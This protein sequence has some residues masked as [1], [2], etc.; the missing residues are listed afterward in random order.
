MDQITFAMLLLL[1]CSITVLILTTVFR[2]ILSNYDNINQLKARIQGANGWDEF[3]YWKWELRDLYCSVIPGLTPATVKRI[4]LAIAGRSRKSDGFG[5]LLMPSVLCICV[6]AVGLMGGTFAWFTASTV[7]PVQNIQAGS[8][9]VDTKLTLN[10]VELMPDE[11]GVYMLESGETYDIQLIADGTA[12]NGYCIVT[13]NGNDLHTEQISAVTEDGGFRFRIQTEQKVQMVVEARWGVSSRYEN[14]DIC[15][16]QTYTVKAK[17]PAADAEN[18]ADPPEVLPGP[19]DPQPA[20]PQQFVHT[21]VAGDTLAI[22]AERYNCD[23]MTL[24]AYN[25]ITDIHHIE[26]GQKIWIPPAG[27]T[28]PEESVT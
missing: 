11:K 1:L 6:C 7:A 18:P 9:K 19:T 25:N 28:A 4:R 15:A 23:M 17:D 20:Q 8:Y 22:I 13:L 3:V 26:I 5:A 14:P 24:A 21:V 10:G 16:N 2:F 12:A 27:W